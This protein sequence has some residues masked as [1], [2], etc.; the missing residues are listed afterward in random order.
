[1]KRIILKI[2]ILIKDKLLLGFI[3]KLL[4]A[5]RK[6]TISLD[7]MQVGKKGI[8]V[9]EVFP[10]TPSNLIIDP[11]L[12]A[13]TNVLEI[14]NY[15]PEYVINPVY[16]AEVEKG[17]LMTDYT[18]IA[19]MN[20]NRN[21]LENFSIHYDSGYSSKGSLR[22]WGA[23][24]QVNNN[25]YHRNFYYPPEK[26]KGTVLNMHTG[27][28]GG[29]YYHFLF[30]VLPGIY[31]AEKAGLLNQVDFF[32]FQSLNKKFQKEALIS[33]GIDLNKVITQEYSYHFST[34][35]L[36]T[37]THPGEWFHIPLWAINFLREQFIPKIIPDKKEFSK[38]LI[39]RKDAASGRNIENEDEIFS[40]LEP[41]GFKRI[42]LSHYS[43]LDQVKIFNSAEIIISPHGAGLANLVFCNPN[44][45]VIEVFN[46]DF[47][48]PLFHSLS[49][50]LN[51]NHTFLITSGNKDNKMNDAGYANLFI[52]ET[53][54]FEILNKSIIK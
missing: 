28:G 32:Y 14:V 34:E 50:R 42:I 37:F 53:K 27:G 23:K 49:K 36:I 10:V 8:R 35:K 6:K 11:D 17:R 19:I 40:K 5:P 54:L 15:K 48:T 31:I 4:F 26:I 16:I 29:S 38:L 39:S 51:I 45:F 44:T 33:L 20:E 9:Q 21:L 2:K 7:E 25:L 30:D 18:D 3:N 12:L 24:N 41:L 46:H 52:E 43:F 22:V 13:L 47:I 1:M